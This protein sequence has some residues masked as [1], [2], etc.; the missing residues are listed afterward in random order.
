[1]GQV[2]RGHR[3]HYDGFQNV[4]YIYQTWTI[5]GTAVEHRWATFGWDTKTFTPAF[6]SIGIVGHYQSIP[7]LTQ[8]GL[9]DGSRYNFDYTS[10]GQI[11]IIHRTTRDNVERSYTKYVY[12][13]PAADCPRITSARIWAKAGATKRRDR[14]A[15]AGGGAASNCSIWSRHPVRCVGAAW[16]AAG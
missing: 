10:N 12:D 15:M 1:M 14:H 9:P 3:F 8:V 6:S 7:V 13:A 5:N 2:K 11:E 16:A 4:D